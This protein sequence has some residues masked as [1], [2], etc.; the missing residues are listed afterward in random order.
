MSRNTESGVFAA[1]GHPTRRAILA[2]LRDHDYVKVGEIADAVGV[3]GSTL[4]GHLRTLREA[5]VGKGCVLRVRRGFIDC[6]VI[7]HKS[8]D[9]WVV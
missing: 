8:L 9:V 7:G 1:L 2:F 6:Q 3:S 5:V 4:S